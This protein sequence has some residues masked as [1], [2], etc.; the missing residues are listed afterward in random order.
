[1]AGEEV[2]KQRRTT[3]IGRTL[4]ALG[5]RLMEEE[6]SRRETLSRAH[7]GRDGERNEPVRTH[8]DHKRGWET[9]VEQPNLDFPARGLGRGERAAMESDGRAWQRQ[10]EKERERSERFSLF[11]WS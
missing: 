2:E 9:K 4:D 10:R 1:V 6:W 11:A 7:E 3:V 8:V 5:L